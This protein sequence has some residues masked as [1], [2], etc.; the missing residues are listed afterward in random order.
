M[1]GGEVAQVEHSRRASF[2]SDRTLSEGTPTSPPACRCRCEALMISPMAGMMFG[3]LSILQFAG[4]GVLVP[5]KYRESVSVTSSSAKA[6]DPVHHSDP[7]A[8]QRPL[9]T[10]ATPA[11]HVVPVVHLISNREAASPPWRCMP[12]VGAQVLPGL[13]GAWARPSGASH[14]SHTM[15][16]QGAVSPWTRA[17]Q[18]E[19]TPHAT[20]HKDRIQAHSLL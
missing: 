2:I 13:H 20:D 1:K 18:S 19:Q 17:R 5:Y 9:C 12:L 3:E 6:S 10:T 16:A 7:C 4:G 11:Q 8:P 14:A 15:T